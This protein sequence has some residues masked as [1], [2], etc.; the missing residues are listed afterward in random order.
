MLKD[1]LISVLS[2]LKLTNENLIKNQ[3]FNI[4]KTKNNKDLI[5]TN[6]F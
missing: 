1:F 4:K 5:K 2:N 6:D 3:E